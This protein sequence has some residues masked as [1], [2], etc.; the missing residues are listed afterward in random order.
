MDSGRKPACDTVLLAGSNIAS[1]CKVLIGR[2]SNDYYPSM[3]ELYIKRGN[4]CDHD[5]NN[6]KQ[7]IPP[8]NYKIRPHSIEEALR[9]LKEVEDK[10]NKYGNVIPLFFHP[11]DKGGRKRRSERLE[12]TKR[13][14]L[15]ALINT[16]NLQAMAIGYYNNRN[17][18]HYF[19]YAKLILLT[20][21]NASRLK[22]A[23]KDLQDMELV[24]VVSIREKDEKGRYRTREVK[25][26]FTD[27]IF[28]MLHLMDEFLKDRETSAIKFHEKQS[29]LD[30]N[31]QKKEN[32]RKPFFSSTIKKA[33][34]EVGNIG[35]IANKIGKPIPKPT[36]GRGQEIKE[37]Y[38]NLIA[39]GSTPQEAAEIIRTKY[40]PPH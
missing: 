35:G 9:R 29:R 15:A 37:L 40:P 20:E 7:F 8:K 11:A 26:E 34:Q 3:Q 4:R 39:R 33:K 36:R 1:G 17:E 13:L 14:V 6:L 19:G 27:K 2:N 38:G 31:R 25:I 16:L 5:K 28:Q 23:M 18:F 10:P 24:K 30:K 21:L 32:F 12:S 22:R